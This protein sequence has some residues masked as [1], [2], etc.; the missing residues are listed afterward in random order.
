M[1]KPKPFKTKCGSCG[2]VIFLQ[3]DQTEGMKVYHGDC[4]AKLNKPVGGKK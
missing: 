1:S 3:K 2:K 4:F